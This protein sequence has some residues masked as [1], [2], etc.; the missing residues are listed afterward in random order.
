MPLVQA[1]REAQMNSAL[2]VS[3]GFGGSCASLM[4]ARIRPP[5]VGLNHRQAGKRSK[6]QYAE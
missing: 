1:T 6:Q 2:S 3:F 4:F 5:P